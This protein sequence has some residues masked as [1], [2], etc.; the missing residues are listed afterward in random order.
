[1]KRF[2]FIFLALIMLFFADSILAQKNRWIS[3]IS[4]KALPDLQHIGVNLCMISVNEA[5]LSFVLAPRIIFQK[6]FQNGIGIRRREF[7]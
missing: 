6:I 2:Y 5:T 3:S 4:K 7:N 1:M